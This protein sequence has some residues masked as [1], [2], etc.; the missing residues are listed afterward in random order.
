MLNAEFFYTSSLS[1][2]TQA[3]KCVSSLEYICTDALRVSV[4]YKA[5]S[6][7]SAHFEMTV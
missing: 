7:R 1:S 4:L 2:I 6:V 3:L 5:T